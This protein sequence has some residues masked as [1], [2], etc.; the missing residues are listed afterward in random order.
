MIG[1]A[2]HIDHGKTVLV[3]ALTGWDTDR[4]PEEKKRG[5]SIDL[6][7][8]ELQLDDGSSASVVDV[9]G[10]ERF[11]RNMVAG[12]YGIDLALVV[13]AADEGVMPQTREHL[14]I[15]DLLGIDRGVAAVTKCDLV[16]EELRELA[17]EE[18]REEMADRLLR[19][20]PVIPVSAFDGLGLDDLMK[21]LT[22]EAEL[23]RESRGN[24]RAG[25]ARL[26]VDRAF[27]VAGI[28][29]VVTGTLRGSPISVGDELEV[30][31]GNLATRARSVQIHGGPVDVASP[32][33]RVAI[34]VPGLSPRE[35]PRGVWVGK[36]R[37]FSS[38]R[39]LA[40]RIR[41]LPQSPPIEEGDILTLHMGTAEVST[42]VVVLDGEHIAPGGRGFARLHPRGG[43]PAAFGDRFILRRP[44]PADTVA[45]GQI[46]DVHGYRYRR[47][48]GEALKLLEERS[49]GDPQRVLSAA[50]AG[51]PAF[52]FPPRISEIE[53]DL[54]SLAGSLQPVV[55]EL[56]ECGEVI[57]P[58]NDVAILSDDWEQMVSRILAFAEES[59]QNDPLSQGTPMEEA[60]RHLYPSMD[61]ESFEDLVRFMGER[62]VLRVR[63]GRIA[64]TGHDPSPDSETEGIARDLLSD[65]A[66]RGLSPMQRDEARDRLPESLRDSLIAYLIR[67]GFVVPAGEFLVERGVWDELLRTLAEWFR[68]EETITVSQLRTL[69]DTTRKYA[70]PLAEALDAAR[71]TLRRGDLRY[72]GPG[73]GEFERDAG[74]D[75]NLTKED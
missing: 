48:R 62:G 29:T 60:A 70:V 23:V 12:S 4:L 22:R 69:A 41:V 20:A 64:P 63:S 13:V 68:E 56:V 31:P 14:D 15:I 2:G 8:A 71:I 11:V 38:H 26:P 27:T 18:I 21:A 73:L 59:V 16:D 44:S 57:R 65:L 9:P 17:V 74:S 32:G 49:S 36:P 43:I 42:R 5:I 75:D 40:A 25:P 58:R 54:A 51:V 46:L 47:G 72:R 53:R 52:K 10:H 61:S 30:V 1:T 67:E 50:L 37:A 24:S 28:G 7:F 45:G 34:N 6:G 35:L 19:D 55:E 39:V 66:E 3:R 33:G